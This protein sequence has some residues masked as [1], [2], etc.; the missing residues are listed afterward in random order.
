MSVQPAED[1]LMSVWS[2]EDILET[3]HRWPCILY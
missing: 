3:V 2:T 1:V